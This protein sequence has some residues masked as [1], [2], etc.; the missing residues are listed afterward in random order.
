MR[1]GQ[2]SEESSIH[3]KG[4]WRQQYARVLWWRDRVQAQDIA[5]NPNSDYLQELYAFFVICLSLRDWLEKS[6]AVPDAELNGLFKTSAP[7]QAC[8]DIANGVKHF[9][10]DPKRRSTDALVI[11]LQYKAPPFIVF[12]TRD[13][14]EQFV[15]LPDL[16]NSC[17]RDWQLFLNARSLLDGPAESR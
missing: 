12:R 5:A 8:R 15:E 4:G 17:V 11:L 6:G 1:V 9:E 7:L 10:L 14:Y 13:G 3:T 2:W 16:V